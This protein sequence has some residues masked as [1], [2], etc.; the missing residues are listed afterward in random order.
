MHFPNPSVFPLELK[1]G[2]GLLETE[3]WDHQLVNTKGATHLVDT[4][5]LEANG[6]DGDEARLSHLVSVQ[7]SSIDFEHGLTVSEGSK[8][9]RESMEAS[10]SE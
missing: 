9:V 8:V 3:L 6:V 4:Y 2:L 10:S 5:L 7:V 1:T